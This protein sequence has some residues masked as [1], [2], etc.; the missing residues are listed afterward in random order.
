M[1][2]VTVGTPQA[3][4]GEFAGGGERGKMAPGSGVV[5]S[6][7]DE[8]D[9]G[10]S[11][12][13]IDDSSYHRSQ[14]NVTAELKVILLLY[15][16]INCTLPYRSPRRGSP[17][18]ASYTVVGLIIADGVDTCRRSSVVRIGKVCEQ[19]GFGG[20]HEIVDCIL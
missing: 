3:R 15:K 16:N 10:V 7:I 11:V 8:S 6:E 5:L 9:G 1:Q 4:A 12:S 19:H 17:S 18:S 14:R 13:S 20:C 2:L